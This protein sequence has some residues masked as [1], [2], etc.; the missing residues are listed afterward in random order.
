MSAILTRELTALLVQALPESIVFAMVVFSFLCLRFDLKKIA[1]IAMLQ[2]LTNLV[3]LLPIAFGVHTVVLV[4]SLAF[5]VHLMTK[6]H[7]S[8]VFMAVFFTFVATGL[9][10]MIYTMPLL[11]IT[12]RTY[13]EVFTSPVLREV[14]SIPCQLVLLAVAL[15]KNYYNHQRGKISA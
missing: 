10:E 11:K 5:Y 15:G 3:S 12:G 2:S 14:Y 6:M 7:L 4:I 8:R 9:I 13:Q 1:T